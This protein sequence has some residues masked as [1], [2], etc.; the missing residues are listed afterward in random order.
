VN[1]VSK[2]PKF[3]PKDRI[4]HSVHGLGTIVEMGELHTTIAFDEAG[5][6]KFMTA[7]VQLT[8]SDSPAPKAPARRKKR[9]EA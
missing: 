1:T 5:T 6:R 7:M 4:L 9:V 3:L 8:R 2:T